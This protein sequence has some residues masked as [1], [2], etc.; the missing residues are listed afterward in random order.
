MWPK[1]SKLLYFYVWNTT[2]QKDETVQKSQNRNLSEHQKMLPLCEWT[3]SGQSENSN[4]WDI[5]TVVQM[6][7]VCVVFLRQVKLLCAW[8]NGCAF[9]G[10]ET[11]TCFSLV[12]WKCTALR[13]PFM[14]SSHP[15]PRPLNSYQGSNILGPYILLKM[16][17]AK[18]LKISRKAK[19][20]SKSVD[21][22]TKQHRSPFHLTKNFKI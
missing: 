6:F 8:A 22:I 9:G 12:R 20:S 10:K 15:G 4:K 18:N 14:S 17:L 1:M 11:H 19:N 3:R 21:S 13:T 2:L 7:K 16:I 5:E